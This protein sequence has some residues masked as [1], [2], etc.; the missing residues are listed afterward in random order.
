MTATYGTGTSSNGDFS[1]TASTSSNA[2]LTVNA[3]SEGTSISISPATTSTTYGS[4]TGITYSGTVA[5]QNNDGYP[6]G[7]VTVKT[8]GGTTLYSVITL[9]TGSGDTNAYS[10]PISSNTLLAASGT[11][12]TVTATYAPGAASSSNS[13]FSYTAS[14]SSNA[15]PDRQRRVRG[16]L[17]LDLAGH[18]VDHLRL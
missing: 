17:D 1:Y 11:A 4:E 14:T 5:G 16:H 2:S 12:Y 13:N 9:G 10:C 15:E 8:S 7:T 6:E 18:D 3:E